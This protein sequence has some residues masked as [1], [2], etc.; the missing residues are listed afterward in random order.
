MR[1]LR[2]IIIP[3]AAVAAGLVFGVRLN[4]ASEKGKP[5]PDFKADLVVQDGKPVAN[6]NEKKVSLADYKGKSAVILNFFASWCGPCRS[7]YPHLKELDEQYGK[8]G[9]QVVSVSVDSERQNAG[10]LAQKAGAKFPVAWDPNGE[11]AKKY[12]VSAI[13]LNVV[14]DAQGNVDQVILGADIAALK[15]AAERLAK[16]KS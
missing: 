2:W 12:G 3:A 6:G 13:P 11:V 9:V 15:A 16:P 14:I 8:R 7:E 5:A 10:M 4:A 1:N